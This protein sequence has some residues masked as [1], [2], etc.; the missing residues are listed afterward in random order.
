[1]DKFIEKIKKDLGKEVAMDYVNSM[2]SKKRLRPWLDW[3]GGKKQRVF[4]DLKKGS[5]RSLQVL[6]SCSLCICVLVTLSCHR[7]LWV[8]SALPFPPSKDGHMLGVPQSVLAGPR[9]SQAAKRS[10]CWTRSST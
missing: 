9:C 6:F 5:Y 1:M 10:P 7:P 4:E 2:E 8:K 3:S